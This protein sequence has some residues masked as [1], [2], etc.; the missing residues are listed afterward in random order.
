MKGLVRSERIEARIFLLH[1]HRV[2]L[3]TDLAELYEVEP[4]VLVQAVK[5]NIERFPDDFVF[6][7]TPEDA[8]L[9]RSQSVTGKGHPYSRSRSQSV[10]LKRGQNI[11]YLPYAFT[12][13]GV[14]M[15]SSVL[16]SRRAVQVNVAIMRAFVRLRQLLSTNKELASKLAELERRL[17]D[18]DGHIRSLFEAI[19]QLMTPTET[20]RW[21]IGFRTGNEGVSPS[22]PRSGHKL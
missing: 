6:Q 14:A 2:M 8:S 21:R 5:R 1:G 16:R 4:R 9:L 3:S 19:R 18:H 11:K 22:G 17:E 12:E 13:E 15:L 10:I 20:K 7:L